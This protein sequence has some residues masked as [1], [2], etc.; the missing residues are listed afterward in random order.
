MKAFCS[1]GDGLKHLLSVGERGQESDANADEIVH[2][3]SYPD[4]SICFVISM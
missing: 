1:S 3:T 2:P 4:V